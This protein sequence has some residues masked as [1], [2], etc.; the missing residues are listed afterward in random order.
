VGLAYADNAWQPPYQPAD[1]AGEGVDSSD[2]DDEPK[3]VGSARG[4]DSA[5]Q[6]PQSPPVGP[7]TSHD[8]GIGTLLGTVRGANLP[9]QAHV[10]PADC[11]VDFADQHRRTVNDLGKLSRGLCRPS[12]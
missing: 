2:R 10:D 1:G 9:T 7:S 6:V 3:Q 11:G 8:S 12:K 5:D 4:V